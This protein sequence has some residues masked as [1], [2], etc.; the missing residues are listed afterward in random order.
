M[1]CL[2]QA[3]GFPRLRKSWKINSI[4]QGDHTGNR[5]NPGEFSR[6]QDLCTHLKNSRDGSN[7]PAS[8]RIG[9]P[10]AV[11]ALL[12][13][14]ENGTFD[15][16]PKRQRGNALTPSLALRVS[17][18]S[19]RDQYTKES[20]GETESSSAG[21]QLGKGCPGL[22]RAQSAS[23]PCRQT[24]SGAVL[25]DFLGHR[26]DPSKI[27][28]AEPPSCTDLTSTYA[29]PRGT[30]KA[31]ISSPPVINGATIIGRWPMFNHAR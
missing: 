7:P 15:T 3:P 4:D 14:S 2:R 9:F 25:L 10:N 19:N 21:T 18:I 22:R 6:L 13:A 24:P 29:L 20:S 8:Q 1:A 16:N 5:R 31:E 23:G 26:S 28:A 27:L 11:L 12:P 17:V 30:I